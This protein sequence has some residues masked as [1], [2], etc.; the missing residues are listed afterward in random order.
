MFKLLIV[1]DS[2]LM[3]RH[4]TELFQS[5]G[6]FAIE[7]ARHG[8]EAVEFNRLW[9]PDVVLLDINMPVMDG[10]TALARMMVERPVPVV[11]LSSLTHR[12]AL[13]TFEALN[14]GALD[15]VPKP[16]GTISL[17]LDRVQDELVAKVRAA[18]RVRHKWRGGTHL[19]AGADRPPP[20][21]P[22]PQASRPAEPFQGLVV[23]GVS[24]GGPR[25]LEM[26]LPQLPAAWGWAVL[27]AQHMPAQFSR[28]FAERMGRQCALKVIEVCEPVP[29]KRDT[30]YIGQGGK[31]L[32]IAR[33]G[34]DWVA[35][36]KPPQ[37][38]LLWH[39]SVDDLV[40]S[41]LQHWD[42]TRTI[43]V[44]LTGMG[45]DG[46]ESL[47]QLKL[48][49]G[50]TIAESEETAVVFGMPHSLIERGGATVVL[51]AHRIAPQIVAWT[52]KKV[53]Q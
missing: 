40:Q 18:A 39:P 8:A 34:R 45:Y 28:P 25:T 42:P 35:F 21:A 48:R 32:R 9:Q 44:L 14:L 52:L 24:T 4:L 5:L 36:P 37:E 26:I 16:D 29:L 22:T 12:G 30:I 11:M 17:S 43:G 15:Y 31:D 13:A 6:T 50:L 10:L 1:D 27:V 2:A 3:R 33:R 47:A 20:A 23:I 7:T 19:T 41:V 46:A 51:P 49:G 53:V 38:T